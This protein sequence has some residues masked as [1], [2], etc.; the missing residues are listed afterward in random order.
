MYEF[1]SVTELNNYASGV[2]SSDYALSNFSV[3]GEI[4]GFTINRSSGHAYFTVKDKTSQLSC[5]MFSTYLSRVNFTPKDGMLVRITGSA[6]MYVP[7]GKY[8]MKVFTMQRNGQG[9]LLEQY[10]ILLDKL[11]S[12]GLFDKAH[13]KPLPVLPRRIGVITSDTGEVI[14]DIITTLRRRNPHFDILVYPVHVQG[15]ECPADVVN[16]L[17]YFDINKSVDVIIIARGGGSIEDLFGFNDERMARAIFSCSIPVI[18]AIGH[19]SDYSICDYVADL[20]APTPTAAAELVLT[21]INDFCN[22][23]SNYRIQL[24]LS[25]ASYI[26]NAQKKVDYLRNH[27]ALYSPKFYVEKQLRRLDSLKKD[28]IN[29]A[30][31]TIKDEQYRLGLATKELDNSIE[32]I[33]AERSRI[34]SSYIDKLDTLGPMSVLK[35]GFAYVSYDNKPISSISSMRIND[36]INIR[37]NDGNVEATIDKINQEDKNG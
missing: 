21:S 12:E 11:N 6:S 35:R 16:A 8:Q 17:S 32:R 36:K 29:V 14:H 20:R 4:S 2:L 9:D 7:Y 28:L 18:S 25:I 27:K 22:E 13:K 30:N 15:E 31:V 34:L 24:N 23:I 5:I 19:E 10:K 33:I 26:N 37:L 1:N 3:V